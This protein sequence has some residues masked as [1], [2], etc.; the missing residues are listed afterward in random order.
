MRRS[1]RPDQQPT[2]EQL[3]EALRKSAERG[4]TADHRYSAGEHDLARVDVY[5]PRHRDADQHIENDVGG[6]DEKT[7]LLVGQM[8][9]DLDALGHHAKH[10]R[11]EEVEHGGENDHGKP[12]I[13]DT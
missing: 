9:V 1:A 7:N 12:V 6:S 13:G 5:Q 11:V 2:E 3:S 4:D 8:K 10:L